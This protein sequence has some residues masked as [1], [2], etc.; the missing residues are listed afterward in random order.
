M[1][2][3]PREMPNNLE[4]EQALL[5]AALMN[6]QAYHVVSA[7]LI[8]EDFYEP[9]HQKIWKAIADIVM[10]DRVANPVTVK[11]KLKDVDIGDFKLSDYLGTL[12]GAA[13]NIINAPDYASVVHDLSLRRAMISIGEDMIAKAYDA[14]YS[15]PVEGQI[16]DAEQRIF[17]LSVAYRE[18]QGKGRFAGSTMLT[19]YLNYVNPDVARRSMHGVPIGLPELATVLSERV[20]EP[21]NVYGLLAASGE[22]KTS[23]LLVLVRAAVA[24]GN[25]V[26]ILS[27]DQSGEQIVAQMVAQEMGVE[28]RIQRAGNMTEKQID[29]ATAYVRKLAQSPFEVKDCDS[30]KDTAKKLTRYVKE[31]IRKNSNGKT[32][33]IVTDHAATIKPERDDKNADQGTK[34]RNAIQEMKACAK[35][36]GSAHLVLMQRGSEGTKRFN[37]RPVKADVYGGQAAIQPWDAIAYLYRAEVYLQEQQDTAKNDKEKAEIEARF[38]QQYGSDIENTAELGALKVRFGTTK[39][40]RKVKF[41]PEYTLY[42]SMYRPEYDQGAMF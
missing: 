17:E 27:Y 7:Y 37:P 25:P 12:A 32:P 29:K 33:F 41:I 42:E 40:K 5:G 22:G 31:F 18:Q 23:L 28:T 6:N 21:T 15:E 34:A 26:L 14:E 39:Q 35:A 3:A 36:T 9:I 11:S 20:F 8:P 16:E 19:Q 24:A 2:N 13:V 4:A 10:S 38:I 30:S 1:S